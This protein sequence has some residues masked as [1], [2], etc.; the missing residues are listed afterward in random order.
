[1]ERR[2]QLHCILTKLRTCGRGLFNACPPSGFLIS[3][4]KV[5]IL[6][7]GPPQLGPAM[8]YSLLLVAPHGQ[9]PV[10]HSG[11]KRRT[12]LITSDF[13]SPCLIIKVYLGLSD[14]SDCLN[15]DVGLCRY[16][17]LLLLM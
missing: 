10:D 16:T 17:L 8:A 1:M 12:T 15:D 7:V 6:T 5:R 14:A 13:L 4:E 3:D 11:H 2:R 9:R